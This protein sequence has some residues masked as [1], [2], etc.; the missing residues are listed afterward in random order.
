MLVTLC[1]QE[2]NYLF[3]AF[4]LKLFFLEKQI[5]IGLWSMSFLCRLVRRSKQTTSGFLVPKRCGI[6]FITAN[7]YAVLLTSSPA[8]PYKRLV[9]STQYSTNCFLQFRRQNRPTSYFWINADFKRH[10]AI[11]KICGVVCNAPY[12]FFAFLN[13]IFFFSNRFYRFHYIVLFSFVLE[14]FCVYGNFLDWK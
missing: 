3:T 7:C 14:H 10:V 8:S 13:P 4:L 2:N 11:Y 1:F 9:T 6:L 5:P 12:R